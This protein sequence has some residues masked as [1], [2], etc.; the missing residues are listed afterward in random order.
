MKIEKGPIGPPPGLSSE[1]E[2]SWF[3]LMQQFDK[4]LPK[5]ERVDIRMTAKDGQLFAENCVVILSGSYSSDWDIDEYNDPKDRPTLSFLRNLGFDY[6]Q[7]QIPVVHS[8]GSYNIPILVPRWV[9][10]RYKSQLSQLVTRC[11]SS[12]DIFNPDSVFKMYHL[13]NM[14][15]PVQGTDGMFCWLDGQ[16]NTAEHA[17]LEEA[18]K[19]LAETA[20]LEVSPGRIN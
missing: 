10:A 12:D 5:R 14:S 17:D 11:V 3:E 2:K 18:R 9:P 13:G 7:F 6:K 20:V 19:D 1:E 16:I 15:A 8:W 4:L